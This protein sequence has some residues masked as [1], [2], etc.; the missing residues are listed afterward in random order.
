MALFNSKEAD[1]SPAFGDKKRNKLIFTSTRKG[2]AGGVDESTGQTHSDLFETTLDKNGKWSTPV[3][4]PA[5]INSE[6]NEGAATIS[7]KADMIV[8][9][10]VLEAK[11]KKERPNLYVAKKSGAAWGDPTKIPFCIDSINFAHPTLTGD[12]S[13]MYFASNT[14]GSIGHA[15]IW[16]TNYNKKEDIEIIGLI[17]AL[18]S[19]QYM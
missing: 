15:D 8:F 14:Q 9:S 11:G 3:P 2:S 7:K 10:R 17:S 16:M 13:I 12:A 18:F 5:P 1:F 4:L 6:V 19:Y